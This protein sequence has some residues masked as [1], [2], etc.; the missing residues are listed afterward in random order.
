MQAVIPKFLLNW[1]QVL[2]KIIEKSSK[3]FYKILN[4][5]LK[6]FAY[7]QAIDKHSENSEGFY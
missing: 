5:V 7:W 6:Y 1:G 2:T 3:L 4:L